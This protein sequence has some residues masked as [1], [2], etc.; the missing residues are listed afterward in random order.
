MIRGVFKD[1][2]MWKTFLYS[3]PLPFVSSLNMEYNTSL[4]APGSFAHSLQRHTSCNTS[5]PAKSKMANGVLK[6][7]KPYAFG[8]N[9][10]RCPGSFV[11][12]SKN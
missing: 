7:V 2:K 6:H 4:V 5:P 9:S 1:M 11:S 8:S 12:S 3:L 10:L